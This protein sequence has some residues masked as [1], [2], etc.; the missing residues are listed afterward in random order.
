MLRSRALPPE[1]ACG[2][3]PVRLHERRHPPTR[4][5]CGARSI[6]PPEGR[7]DLRKQWAAVDLGGRGRRNNR[8]AERSAVLASAVALLIRTCLGIDSTPYPKP[9]CRS[10]SSRAH[11]DGFNK[12]SIPFMGLSFISL[13]PIAAKQR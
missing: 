7:L 3:W 13:V 12:V 10:T 4:S 2:R 1:G 5:C 11:S 8:H 9:A 6:S